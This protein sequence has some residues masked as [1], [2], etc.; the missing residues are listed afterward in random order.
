MGGQRALAWSSDARG[1]LVTKTTQS[2]TFT[3]SAGEIQTSSSV[4]PISSLIP[5]VRYHQTQFA[6]A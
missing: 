1:V 6:E 3:E 2:V 4:T 5:L